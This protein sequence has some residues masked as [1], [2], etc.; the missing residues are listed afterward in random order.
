MTVRLVCTCGHDLNWHIAGERRCLERDCVCS[1]MH[2]AG[3]GL[4]R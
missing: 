2:P 1:A 3:K 4:G